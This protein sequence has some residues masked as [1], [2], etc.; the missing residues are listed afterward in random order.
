[1]S[2]SLR[3]PVCLAAI[4]LVLVFVL[5][6]SSLDLETP[7]TVAPHGIVSLEVAG[8]VQRADAIKAVWTTKFGDLQRAWLSIAIDFGFILVYS[9]A[10]GLSCILAHEMFQAKRIGAG[11]GFPRMGVLLAWGASIAGLLDILE[12]LAMMA[13]L[14]S[15]RAEIW[16]QLSH[17]FATVKFAL[18][19]ACLGYSSVGVVLSLGDWW[20]CL[21]SWRRA[22]RNTSV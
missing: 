6:L 16:P 1:M 11:V 5:V 10:L 19:L 21:F 17:S 18:V 7:N 15:A 9:M 13:M 20:S 14:W 2:Q 22:R 12:N 4:P 3:V 8:T